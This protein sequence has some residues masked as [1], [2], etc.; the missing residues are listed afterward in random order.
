[1]MT[2]CLRGNPFGYRILESGF[3]EANPTVG[4][5]LRGRTLSLVHVMRN[6][7][8]G[9][10]D[11]GREWEVN[12]FQD[13]A[14]AEEAVDEHENTG[15]NFDA[16]EDILVE[17]SGDNVAPSV[18]T[19]TEIDLGEELNQNI[20]RCKYVKPTHVQRHTIPISLSGWDLM[21]CA[22][23]GSGKT[24][25]FCFPIISGIMMSQF[26]LRA[27]GTSW[28]CSFPTCSYSISNKGAFNSSEF[29]VLD[30]IHKVL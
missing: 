17:T 19:F 5:V 11:R 18:N 16:Y 6:S 23:T 22:K 20:R 7:R 27:S 12:P 25:A 24:A 29:L 4:K 10:W 15:I 1:M 2:L 9:G 26:A 28:T 8:G 3:C 30:H 14:N 21:A 13:E